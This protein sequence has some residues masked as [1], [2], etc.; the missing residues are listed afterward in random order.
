MKKFT[1]ILVFAVFIC[2]ISCKNENKETS[3]DTLKTT[4]IK[5]DSNINSTNTLGKEYTSK[6]ICANHCKGSGSD[7]E[8]ICPICGM[9]LIENLDYKQ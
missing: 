3:T 5:T 2:F 7:K 1:I 4:E 6:Y 9:E 8:G